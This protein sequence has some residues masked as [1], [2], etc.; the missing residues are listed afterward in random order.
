MPEVP[1]IVHDRLRAAKPAD[2]HPDADVLTAFAEQALPA[3]ERDRVT[4][5]LSRCRDCREIVA[6]GLPALEAVP[7]PRTVAEGVPAGVAPTAE[8]QR[9]WLAWPNLRWAALAAGV[10]VVASML[11]LRPGKPPDATVA[12]VDQ[13]AESPVSPAAEAKLAPP[14]EVQPPAHV[15]ATPRARM[16]QPGP[17]M[18]PG[19]S[20]TGLAGRRN[21]SDEARVYGTAPE[22]LR[23]RKKRSDAVETDKLMAAAPAVTGRALRGLAPGRTASTSE[24]VTVAEAE[25]VLAQPPA[26]VRLQA[27]NEPPPAIVKAKPP[28]AKEEGKL[29]AQSGVAAMQE[30]TANAYSASKQ[31]SFMHKALATK[32]SAMGA[33]SLVQGVLFRAQGKTWKVALRVAQPLLTFGARAGDVWTGGQAGSLFHSSDNGTTWTQIQPSAKGESLSSDIVSIEL[34]SATDIVLTT[35]SNESWVTAD[36]GKTWEKK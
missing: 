12:S 24:S 32:D 1:K 34:L 8:R 31:D 36:G 11:L 25:P 7:Q 23:D 26:E 21:D 30:Q 3:I 16:A 27:R 9:N 20:A 5:H 19:E 10:V 13:S 28:A 22:A 2:H 29:Q 18:L 35:N 6:L 17:S 15:P 33:W 14:P 4:E